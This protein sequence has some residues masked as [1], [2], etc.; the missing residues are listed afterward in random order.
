MDVVFQPKYNHGYSWYLNNGIAVKGYAWNEA[1]EL[2]Q[3][4]KLAAVFNEITTRDSLETLLRSLNGLFVVAG[5]KKDRVFIAADRT[6][7]F[8]LFYKSECN[9]LLITDAAYEEAL[10]ASIDQVALEEF[11]CTGYVTGNCTFF[12][13]IQQIQ[14]G[15]YCWFSGEITR[16]FYHVYAR[17]KVI[18]LPFEDLKQELKQILHRVGQRLVKVLNGRT[19]VLPLSGGYDSRL[20]ASLLH[21]NKYQKVICFTYGHPQD[22]EVK[23]SQRVAASLGFEWHFVEYSNQHLKQLMNVDELNSYISYCTNG[24]G[25]IFLQDFY[26]VKRLC[27]NGIIPPD[28]VFVPGHTGDFISGGHLISGLD[29]ANL[30]E[31]ILKRHYALKASVPHQFSD[32]VKRSLLQIEAYENFDNWNLKERQSKFII[33]SNRAYEFFGHQHLIPL[34]DKELVLFF[35]NIELQY[36][37][38]RVLYDPVIFESFFD[39]LHIGFRSALKPVFIRKLSGAYRRI[40]RRL[41]RDNYN[42][43][44]TVLFFSAIQNPGLPW[45]STKLNVNGVLAAWLAKRLPHKLGSK[46]D[47]KWI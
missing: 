18:R 31:N 35:Q 25:A 42:F 26:A 13:D 30:I 45:N 32:R 3:E 22:P 23:V 11:Q 27:Q 46:S 29:N 44:F 38:G 6:R 1:G 39:T 24:M 47:G 34:W 4:Q 14:A 33:N 5:T 43:K 37:L 2:L 15:E 16:K 9:R 17:D 10:E 12:N 7:S 21:L 36:K 8:P 40:Y 41:Y 19:A 20:I 28:G